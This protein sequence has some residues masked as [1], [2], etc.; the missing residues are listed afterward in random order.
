V[1]QAIRINV[2]RDQ[3]NRGLQLAERYIILA[4]LSDGRAAITALETAT[5]LAPDLYEAHLKLG[6]L[7][8][9]APAHEHLQKLRNLRTRHSRG[10]GKATNEKGLP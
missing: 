10:G 3:P 5:T 1:E 2:P 4:A 9:G 7:L 6:E 8:S